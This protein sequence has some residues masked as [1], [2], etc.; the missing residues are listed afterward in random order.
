M[1]SG[2]TLIGV[3]NRNLRTF[4]VSLETTFRLL[5]YIPDAITRISESGIET[6]KQVQRL[7]KVGVHGILVGET[8]MRADNPV[9]VV[10]E[11]MEACR[12]ESR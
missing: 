11:W 10:Q 5:R 6:A 8:L 3:N 7:C 2:A 12:C 1:S 4:E 9:A